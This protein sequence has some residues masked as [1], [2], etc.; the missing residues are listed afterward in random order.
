MD[1]DVSV[2]GV[3]GCMTSDTQVIYMGI[4]N[5]EYLQVPRIVIKCACVWIVQKIFLYYCSSMLSDYTCYIFVSLF[6]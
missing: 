5:I 2:L 3:T 1:T 6:Y 4:H